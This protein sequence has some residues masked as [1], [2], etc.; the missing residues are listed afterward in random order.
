MPELP[1]VE[2]TRQNL[3]SWSAGRRIL[4]V[5]LFAGSPPG[6]DSLLL[7]KGREFGPIGRKGKLIVG[8]LSGGL[9]LLVHLGMTGKL[10]RRTAKEP[11]P[12]YPRASLLLD[13]ASRL[14]FSDP[15]RFGKIR[16]GP[17][18]SLL[19]EFSRLGPDPLVDE[20]DEEGLSRAISGSRSPVKVALMDQARLA[21]LGNIQAAEA[22][23]RAKI[24]PRR[25]ANLLKAAELSA[26][27]S[28][29]KESIRETLEKESGPELSYVEEPGAENPFLVYGR[30]G[31]PC[32]RCKTPISRLVQAGRSTF[33]CPSCQRP[34]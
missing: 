32:P 23:F 15:R 22:L 16:A 25:P 27:L 24:D 9:G 18:P 7:S 2:I 6:A 11:E 8:A 4:E 29:I 20:L 34:R 14:F 30:Q 12:P 17:L 5:Q 26:L 13:D 3:A 10:L 28:G 21:G 31:E 33:Y 19:Q 1:E